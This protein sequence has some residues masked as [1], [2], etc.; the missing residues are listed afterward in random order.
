[1][2]IHVLHGIHYGYR[3]GYFVHHKHVLFVVTKYLNYNTQYHASISYFQQKTF[4]Y[5]KFLSFCK[6]LVIH[7]YL[8]RVD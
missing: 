5:A 7:I 4:V 2:H 8:C 6:L 3:G 1:M